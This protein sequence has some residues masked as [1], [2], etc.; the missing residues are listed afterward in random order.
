MIKVIKKYLYKKLAYLLPYNLRRKLFAL[1]YKSKFEDII[2]KRMVSEDYSFMSYDKYHCIFIHIPKTAGVSITRTLFGHLIGHFSVAEYQIVFSKK[3]F[4]S[5]F[6]FAI[7]RNPWDRVFSAYN[8]LKN[9]GMTEEDKEWANKNISQYTN[10]N[11]FIKNGLK[12]PSILKWRH[13]LPQCDFI[14]VPHSNK[15]LVDFIGHFENI[16]EDFQYIKK[17]MSLDDNLILK[18]ENVNP[19]K[20]LDYRDYYDDKAQKIVSEVY[21]NDI[22]ILGYNFDSSS[23]SLQK[24]IH[25]IN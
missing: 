13:F 15:P 22:K 11:D 6:K 19:G 8:F 10:F 14:C 3:E 5:Y 25:T 24:N 21:K 12:K 16:N 18:H 23:I 9:G 7:V 20:K 17:K 4:N 2:K 1:F